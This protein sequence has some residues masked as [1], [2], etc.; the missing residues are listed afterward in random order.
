MTARVR[1]AGGFRWE[2]VPLEEYKPADARFRDVSR[3]VLFGGEGPRELRYFEVRPGGF[4]T[5]ERH[6]HVHE[7]MTLRGEGRAVVGEEILD[8]RPYDLV[9]VPPLTWHQFHAG[10]DAPLGFL[11]LVDRERDRPELP[12]EADLAALL[13]HPAIAALI[14]GRS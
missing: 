1:Y 5:L 13:R 8:L 2:G 11:C 6:R 7:V 10:A 12:S 4:T 14:R 9:R 3:Q